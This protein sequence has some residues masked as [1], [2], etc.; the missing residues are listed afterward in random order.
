MTM[1]YEIK[2][3]KNV[4]KTLN[5]LSKSAPKDFIRINSFLEEKLPSLEN[6]CA[7]KNAK[8]LKGYDDNRYRWRLGDYRIIGIVENNTFKLIQIIKI[9]KKRDENTYR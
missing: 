2:Y 4:L 1:S 5:K 3:D 6:P 9:A 8:Y 7:L